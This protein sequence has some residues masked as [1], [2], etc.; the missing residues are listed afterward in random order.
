MLSDLG[1]IK[2]H[3][4]PHVSND[5]PFSEAQF[6]TLKYC[7]E[8]PDRFGSIQDARSFCQ[9]FFNWYNKEHHHS[10]IGLMTPEQF[11][12]G[13]AGLIVEERAKVLNAAFEA[14]PNRFKNKMPIPPAIPEC[15]MDQ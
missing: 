13:L 2:T 1:V 11:H 9:D 12:Y 4:R 8:F 14:T 7:P 3:S 6:K 5:N 10:G 15:R